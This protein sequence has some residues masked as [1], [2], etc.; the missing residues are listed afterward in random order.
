M[1]QKIFIV[2]LLCCL[3]LPV[4]FI[5]V[6]SLGFKLGEVQSPKS[7]DTGYLTGYREG[8]NA[9]QATPTPTP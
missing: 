3:I 2:I 4:S 7:F 6:F 1:K 8:V 9:A 5:S